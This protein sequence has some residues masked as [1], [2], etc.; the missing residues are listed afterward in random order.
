M[1]AS[2]SYRP[3]FSSP[4]QSQSQGTID[5]WQIWEKIAWSKWLILSLMCLGALLGLFY[6]FATQP[7]YSA[8]TLLQIEQLKD[9]TTGAELG[10]ELTLQGAESPFTAELQILRSRAVLGNAIEQFQ[11][12][13]VARPR[14]FPVIGAAIARWR[15]P[16]TNYDNV[17][18]K[19]DIGAL[20]IQNET[21]TGLFNE[22]AWGEEKIVVNQLE[23]PPGY[24]DKELVLTVLPNDRYE[25]S[26]AKNNSILIGRVGGLG[27]TGQSA[28]AAFLIDVEIVH[29]NPG[30]QF[31]LTRKSRVATVDELRNRLRVSELGEESRIVKL[32]L[33]GENPAQTVSILDAIVNHYIE[34]KSEAKISVVQ[35]NLQFLEERLPTV[36]SS[37]ERYEAELNEFRL[38]H[39]SIDFNLETESTLKRIVTIEADIRDL[40]VRRQELRTRFTAQHPNITGIDGQKRLLT[41]E[42][43]ELEG[44]VNTLPQIQQQYVTLTRNVDVNS[45]LYTSLLGRAQELNIAMASATS[46][47]SVLDSATIAS[48]PVKPRKKISL[49]VATLLG[50]LAGVFISLFKDSL[51]KG[52]EDP[53]ELEKELGVP[54][55]VTIPRSLKQHTLEKQT[56]DSR[57]VRALAH[58]YPNDLS[59]ESLRNLRSTV[60]FQQN[61]ESNNVILI[62]SAS[63]KVGKSFVSLNLAV[64]LASS[65]KSVVLVD[66]DMR[67]GKL[68]NSFHMKQSPGLSDAV[69]KSLLLDDVIRSTGIKGLSFVPRGIPPTHPSE[70]LFK[71][72]FQAFIECLSV[73]YDHIIVDAPPV[74]A[75]AD[76]GIIGNSAGSTLLV[77]KSGINPVKEI[78]QCKKQLENSSVDV[79]GIVLNNIVMTS[80]SKSYGGYVYQYTTE[81]A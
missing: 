78:A 66:A 14:Y 53:D 24:L 67:R 28:D 1:V 41:Q 43:S 55:V 71:K 64:V 47:I 26:D 10:D 77:V 12:E 36:K 30:Q 9:S 45:K 70:L 42:L 61:P 57:Q 49:L 56:D 35:K 76:A 20:Q 81:D 25:L 75:A 80:K 33:F 40:N 58:R 29:A 11:L 7:L 52:V 3:I 17:S 18:S 39:G 27:S 38:E 6:N 31:V 4:S 79:T 48:E 32:E 5:V 68:H 8:D 72:E 46:D 34:K 59:I 69:G 73:R 65:G 50:L 51:V 44:S 63:P 54:V 16:Q 13:I 37:L 23:V 21:S 60:F 62:T 15:K 22:Y 19:T 2:N 74:L